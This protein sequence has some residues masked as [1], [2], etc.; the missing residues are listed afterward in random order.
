M[1]IEAELTTPPEPCPYLKD[2][3]YRLEVRYVAALSPEEYEAELASG[4]RRFGAVLFRPTCD[5]CRS[6]VPIR[7]PV[8]SFRPSRWQRRVRRR[9]T[10]LE[11]EIGLPAVSDERLRLYREFHD[12]RHERRDWP[13][14][15]MDSVEYFAT[16]VDNLV[17]TREFR[18]RIE[19]RLV[20]IA[21]VDESP[22][23]FNAIY[24]FFD[25]TLRRRNLGTNNILA[26]LDEANRRGKEYVYLGF[27][28][29]GC[30]SMAYKA[31]FRPAEFLRAGVWGPLAPSSPGAS[32]G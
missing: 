17:A 8:T 30:L 29:K 31:A 5:P 2:R 24:A 19:G 4:A 21:Y 18:Y 1:R 13:R 7:V 10:D 25:P 26:C 14:P 12:D 9:N 16:F 23:A 20:G 28:V 22:T 11:V 32:E 6:C 27:W 3:P 15:E